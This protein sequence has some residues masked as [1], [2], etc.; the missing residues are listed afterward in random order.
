MGGSVRLSQVESLAEF[1]VGILPLVGLAFAAAGRPLLA[2]GFLALPAS[3]VLAVRSRRDAEAFLTVYSLLLVV[4]PAYLIFKPLGAS[5][6]PANV[7]GIAALWWWA[8]ARIVPGLGVD[9]Q[10]QPVRL[11]IGLFAAAVLLGYAAA[12]FRPIVPVEVSAADRGLLVLA[13]SAGVALLAA[14]GIASRD[15]LD[16][17]LRRLVML[18]ALLAAL[19]IFQFYT[20]LDIAKVIRVPGLTQNQDIGTIEQRSVFRRVTGTASHPIEFG[21]VLATIFPL[22]VHYALYPPRNARW[23]Y[24]VSAA[25][26]AVGIPMSLSRSA[27]VGMFGGATLLFAGWSW[28]RRRQ[29]LA[30]G[31][32]F[33]I[34]VRLAI[35]GLLGTVKSL[36]VNIASDPSTT[37]RTQDY[38]VVGH[39][40]KERPFLGRGFFTFLPDRYTTLDNGF[41]LILI[42]L[43]FVGLGA[44]ILLFAVGIFSARGARRR[45]SDPETRHLGSALSAALVGT[46]LTFGTFDYLGF[47]MATGTLFLLLGCSGALWRLALRRAPATPGPNPSALLGPEGQMVPA[48]TAS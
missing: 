4:I 38:S 46:M 12:F 6:T 5:G 45:S 42:E 33:L 28:P 47:P 16:T 40:L 8:H 13:G 32:I 11:A 31:G 1:S 15:R 44:L 7:A 43:G 10:F 19:G 21:V 20:G 36:F 30:I 9:N 3:I 35:P 25:T 17:V 22:A 41:L 2:M 26:I 37:G 24:R 39:Y 48:S 34:A 18:A 29:A 27:F 23:R 14:D